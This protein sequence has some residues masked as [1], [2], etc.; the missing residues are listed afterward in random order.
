VVAAHCPHC[1]LVLPNARR[2]PYPEAPMRCPHCR[3]VIGAHRARA[4]GD[5]GEHGARAHGSAAGVVANAARREDGE[6]LEPVLVSGALHAVADQVGCPLDRLRMLDYQQE[7]EQD[8]DLPALADVIATF[9][10]WKKAR[11]AAAKRVPV[12][13]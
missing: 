8:P 4:D 6:I 11:R 12:A 13:G 2:L 5:D 9:G 1:L 3:L 10:S 7:A